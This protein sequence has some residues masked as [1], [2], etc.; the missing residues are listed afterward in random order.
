MFLVRLFLSFVFISNILAEP[1]PDLHLLYTEPI[2]YISKSLE[3]IIDSYSLNRPQDIDI[4]DKVTEYVSSLSYPKR[5]QNKL[6]HFLI[7]E[8]SQSNTKYNI[9]KIIGNIKFEVAALFDFI[10]YLQMVGIPI[11]DSEFL[12]PSLVEEIALYQETYFPSEDTIEGIERILENHYQL[13]DQWNHRVK[14][15]QDIPIPEA[16]AIYLYYRSFFRFYRKIFETPKFKETLKI[17]MKKLPR[18][19]LFQ[20]GDKEYDYLEDYLEELLNESKHFDNLSFSEELDMP[21][22]LTY[23]KLKWLDTLFRTILDLSF[24]PLSLI[25]F[26]EHLKIE[27]QMNSHIHEGTQSFYVFSIGEIPESFFLMTLATPWLY[28]LD[29]KLAVIP[30]GIILE[31]LMRRKKHDY[32]HSSEI[33]YIY[34]RQNIAQFYNEQSLPFIKE[35]FLQFLKFCKDNF[36]PDENQMIIKRIV[37]LHHEHYLSAL[38]LFKNFVSIL[39]RKDLYD[40]SGSI[41]PFAQYMSIINIQSFPRNHI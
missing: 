22:N 27:D 8:L 4:T 41:I 36:T 33:N 29:I 7:E 12:D 30:D 15:A 23:S 34:Q 10:D 16:K 11:E 28:P 35:A 24:T 32:K 2:L 26:S 19:Y 37:N 13:Y 9:I 14:H 18:T 6:I 3:S 31:N 20:I 21:N 40:S 1:L 5:L 39:L 25:G 38:P 17:R